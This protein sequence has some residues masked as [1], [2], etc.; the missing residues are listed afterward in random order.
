MRINVSEAYRE[1]FEV[2]ISQY[3]QFCDRVIDLVFDDAP[4]DELNTY[5]IRKHPDVMLRL[6]DTVSSSDIMRGIID[7]CSVTY[8]TPLEV[9][10]QHCGI[11]DRELM[12]KRYQ[13]SFIGEEILHSY[14]HSLDEYLLKLRAR[15]LLG[16]SK[17]ILNAKTI[18]FILDW[19][20]D[21][22]SFL[23]IKCLLY[24]AFLYLDK[25]IIVQATGKKKFSTCIVIM[26]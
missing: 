11:T 24:E 26:M 5:C 23:S 17:D 10:I 4:T 16:S 25:K 14:Q 9:V 1:E 15:Y 13:R 18:I 21:E 22:T 20:P 6:T 3:Q 8:I 12:I 19:M 7:K 2:F